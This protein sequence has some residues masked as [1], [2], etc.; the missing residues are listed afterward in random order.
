MTG[1]EHETPVRKVIMDIVDNLSKWEQEWKDMVNPPEVQERVS[2][3]KEAIICC[4]EISPL[5]VI[6]TLEENRTYCSRSTNTV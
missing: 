4:D 6:A 1:V 2:V 3:Q 5:T